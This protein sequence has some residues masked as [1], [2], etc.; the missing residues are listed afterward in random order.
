MKNI[1]LMIFIF[2]AF[3]CK[4]GEKDAVL[5][6]GFW[7]ATNNKNESVPGGLYIYSVKTDNN[8]YSKKMMLLK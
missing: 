7:N 5:S 6:I 8:I 4:N 2:F 1:F 3:S